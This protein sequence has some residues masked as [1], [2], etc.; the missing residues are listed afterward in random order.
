METENHRQF[1]EIVSRYQ[2]GS[3][4]R[5]QAMRLLGALGLAGFA[6]NALGRSAVLAQDATPM[7]MATPVLGPQADGSNVWKVG[8]GGMDMET[9][10]DRHAFF[11]KEITVNAGDS[12]FWEFAPMG[13]PGFHTVTFLSGAEVPPIFVPDMVNGTPVASPEGPPRLLV[14][15]AIAFPDGRTEYDGTGTVNSGLD[16]L[17]TPDQPPYMLKFTKAGSYDYQ[18]AVHG[19]VMKAKVTV[20]EAGA[21]LP[22]D[23]AG[24]EAM[25]KQEMDAVLAEGKKALEDAK[26]ATPMAADGTAWDVSAGAGGLSQ[27]R[28]MHFIPGE[29]TIKVGDTVRWTDRTTGEPHTVTFLGGTEQPEDTLVEPQPSGPPKLIQNYQSLLPAGDKSFDGTGYHNS[30]FLGLPPEIGQ[31]LGLNGDSYELTFTKAG[32]YPYYC[33]L[34]SSGPD[35]EYGMTG[36]V[37]VEG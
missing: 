3:I 33:I 36:K 20:Q 24:Y 5:R 28:V 32:E 13:M 23:V 7:P 4:S 31:A 11:P 2:S 27:A 15:P 19:I 26:A 8:V 34:H 6:G 22:T 10:I 9:G 1:A 37:I 25:A 14:N 21:A 17:R 16:V 29:V 30:G 18:C 35:D 12:I